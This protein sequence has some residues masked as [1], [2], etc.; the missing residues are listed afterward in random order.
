MT[1]AAASAQT[2]AMPS[3]TAM[4]VMNQL[5]FDCNQM[6]EV[7]KNMCYGR[8]A[9]PFPTYRLCVPSLIEVIPPGAFCV[10]KPQSPNGFSL[11]YDK[12]D[13]NTQNARRRA[14]GCLPSPN[15]CSV[16]KGYSSANYQCDEYP[17]ASTTVIQRQSYRINRCVPAGENS[18]QGGMLAKFYGQECHSQPCDF[19]VGFTNSANIP[20][21]R[22]ICASSPCISPRPVDLCVIFR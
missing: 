17:F 4:P 7:C 14:A 21:C 8:M 13:K 16:K 22:R 15:R 10:P 1:T 18:K 2:T 12:P 5:I 9:E 20:Y 11:H 19:N 3:A 6:P